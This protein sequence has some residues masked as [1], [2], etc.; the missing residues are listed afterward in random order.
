MPNV[1]NLLDDLKVVEYSHA[2]GAAYCG[3]VFAT[4]GARVTRITKA[5][6]VT[7][8]TY[9]SAP[10]ENGRSAAEIYLDSNKAEVISLDFSAECERA[11]LDALIA[12]CD[13][14]VTDKSTDELAADGLSPEILR[15]RFPRLI[16]TMIS[17][18]GAIGPQSGWVGTDLEAQ[19]SGGLMA[20]LG[21]PGRTPLS[22]PYN[23]ALIHAGTQAAAATLAALTRRDATDEGSLVDISAAQALA[24]SVRSYALLL[25]Y[26]G[27]EAKRSGTRAPGSLGRY[28]V[29]IFPCKDGHAVMTARSGQQWRAMLAMLGDPEWGKNP[30]YQNVRGISFEY[31]DEVDELM[32]PLTRQFT[33]DELSERGLTFKV[34]VGP[35]QTT[36]EVLEDAQFA[37]RDFFKDIGEDSRQLRVPTFPVAWQ[38][39]AA[40][41]SGEAQ[42]P[43]ASAH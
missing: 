36:A 24:A 14:F 34:P 18:F 9:D 37:H 5:G 23:G 33:R 21:W 12:G 27:I 32:F 39:A 3:R 7:A 31:P 1:A 16:Y 2:H 22:V 43:K 25:T 26:Y 19:A 35:L 41:G 8:V 30:R 42:D 10:G 28:P 29:G 11:K 13:I 17:T 20:Q 40:E 4:Q 38:S 15:N 6:D